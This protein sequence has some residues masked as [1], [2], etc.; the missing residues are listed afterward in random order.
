V[1]SRRPISDFLKI[2]LD[3]V[4]NRVNRSYQGITPSTPR[5][6]STPLFAEI[7]PNLDN[8]TNI[9]NAHV[10]E[11]KL[12]TPLV[13]SGGIT[14][15]IAGKMVFEAL[16]DIHWR[17]EAIRGISSNAY[18]EV[19]R[20]IS[21]VIRSVPDIRTRGSNEYDQRVC[22][23]KKKCVLYGVGGGTVLDVTK[24][25][26]HKLNLPYVSVPTSLSTD[27]IASPF[28]V[29]DCDDPDREGP[30]G[31]HTFQTF[32][33]LGVVVGLG[34]VLPR[35]DD[36]RERFGRMLR[37]GIGDLLSNL[38]AYLDWRL[39]EE[40]GRDEVDH[41]AAFE[42]RA[43]A[44]DVLLDILHGVRLD[45]PEFVSGVA[46]ALLTSG[47]AMGRARSSR[48]ASGFA[49]KLYHAH[50]NRL[51]LPS[52]ASHGKMVAV[53][54]LIS[55]RL[56]GRYEEDLHEA[57]LRVGLPTTGEDL[58]ALGLSRDGMEAAIREARQVKP[59]RYT[60]LEHAG[61]DAVIDAFHQVFYPAARA[62]AVSPAD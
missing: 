56:H 27:G 11:E 3:Q 1:A 15:E 10:A 26:A 57:F 12:R 36:D 48:P 50:T 31:N 43:A 35:G 45:D 19:E 25:A 21:R 5:S 17:T 38:T 52:R 47:E 60:I 23:W 2:G 58:E 46:A 39:A 61:A 51:R 62:R 22:G 37:S 14:W 40:Q 44:K 9:V 33:P 29:I 4:I 6:L 18:S 41:V 13:V 7:V 59:E 16:R 20:V 34:N 30:R 49:H 55:A 8:L 53:G 24:M 32:V 54:A 28:A 42:A